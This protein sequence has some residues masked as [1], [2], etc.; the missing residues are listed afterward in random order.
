MDRA[1]ASHARIYRRL[2]VLYP[3]EF[4]AR[5]A[6][7]MV[8]LFADQLREARLDGTPGATARTWLRALGDATVTAASEHARRNRSVAHS[9]GAPP[10]AS[11]RL[12]GLTGILGGLV[13]VAAFLPSIEW[14]REAFQLRLVLFNAGAIA[15]ALAVHR[16]QAAVAPRLSRAVAVAVILANAWYVAMVVL[17]IERP[18]PP[19]PDPDFRLVG[20]IAGAAMWWADAAFG[21]VAWRLG[22]V[23]R[24]GALALAVGSILAFLGMDR[25][26]LVRGETA[27]LFTPIALLGVALNG[28]GWILIGI[29]IAFRRG[30]PTAILR[31]SE[32]DESS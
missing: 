18:Q 8:R 29:D 30:R 25:L 23:T 28:L 5:Y 10:T 31:A 17:S 24:L 21:V 32:G 16:R 6:D 3:S 26:E 27:W 15:L 1:D 19:Q 7:E 13:L 20:F 2:L 14:T 22:A 11:S 4:R 12:L 9:L